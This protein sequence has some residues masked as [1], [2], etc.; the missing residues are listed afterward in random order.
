MSRDD[1]RMWKA[2]DML[3]TVLRDADDG[4]TTSER[5]EWY[6]DRM[7][8]PMGTLTTVIVGPREEASHA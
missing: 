7:D 5:V 3:G 8:S 6:F 2:E 4:S 1:D